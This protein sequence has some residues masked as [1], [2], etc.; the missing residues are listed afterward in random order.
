MRSY[1]TDPDRR[2]VRRSPVS[3][4]TDHEPSVDVDTQQSDLSKQQIRYVVGCRAL[5][6]TTLFRV[7]PTH[8][9]TNY[10]LYNDLLKMF[11][12]NRFQKHARKNFQQQVN[13]VQRCRHRLRVH[14]TDQH[15]VRR[16][17]L[18]GIGF[19]CTQTHY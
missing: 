13:S 4:P 7:R 6:C 9:T 15:V 8:P 16:T 5:L 3:Q 18:H 11:A 10:I 19:L 14:G 2:L 17:Q 12:L 1:R